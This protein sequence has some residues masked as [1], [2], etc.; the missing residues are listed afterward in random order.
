MLT[1]IILISNETFVFASQLCLKYEVPYRWVRDVSRAKLR[2]AFKTWLWHE[3]NWRNRFLKDTLLQLEQAHQV[4]LQYL[5]FENHSS[6]IIMMDVNNLLFQKII[7]KH[8]I[9]N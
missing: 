7:I 8:G 1:Q 2:D 4:L 6:D 3:E 5:R 9:L